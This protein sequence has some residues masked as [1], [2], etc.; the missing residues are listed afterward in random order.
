MGYIIKFTNCDLV[1]YEPTD[2]RILQEKAVV[3]PVPDGFSVREEEGGWYSYI[4]SHKGTDLIK[5]HYLPPADRVRHTYQNSKHGTWKNQAWEP[6][7]WVVVSCHEFCINEKMLFGLVNPK[8]LEIYNSDLQIIG[9][10][11]EKRSHD[12]KPYSG[13]QYPHVNFGIE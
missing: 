2:E 3:T 5:C 1:L 13:S 9:H 12:P 6:N 8:T 4:L 7:Q 11:G 10:L